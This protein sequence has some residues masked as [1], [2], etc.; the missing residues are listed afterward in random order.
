M[1]L[2]PLVCPPELLMGPGYGLLEPTQMPN[3]GT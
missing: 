3:V 2:M 1:M